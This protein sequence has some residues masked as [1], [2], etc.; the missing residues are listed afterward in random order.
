MYARVSRF[1]GSGEPGASRPSAEDVLP[2]LRGMDGFRGLI[3]L[4][5]AAGGDALTITL[6]ESEDAM[7]ATDARADEMRQQIADAAG[8]EI[9]S[10]ERY[11]VEALQLEP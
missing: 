9:R 11:Q 3:S 5:D 1:G 10:V 8:G 2:T 4:V 7:R 6:W